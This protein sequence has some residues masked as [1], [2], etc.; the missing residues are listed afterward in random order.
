MSWNEESA[1]QLGGVGGEHGRRGTIRPYPIQY[2]CSDHV[3]S[4]D[5]VYSFVFTVTAPATPG[6]FTPKYRMVL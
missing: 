6:N 1:I 5:Q 4:G 2:S 3:P